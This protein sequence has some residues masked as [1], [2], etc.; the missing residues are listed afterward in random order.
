MT[1]AWKT[2]L[3]T[4]AASSAVIASGPSAH[5]VLLWNASPS[6][7][8][9]LYRVQPDPQPELTQLVVVH[10]PDDLV[11]FLAEGGYLPRGVPLLKRIAALGGQRVCRTGAAVS[12]DGVS[13][14][15]ALAHDHRGRSLPTW[16][17]CVVL[18]DTQVFLFNADRPDSLDGRYFGPLDRKTIVGRAEPLWTDEER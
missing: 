13:L 16:S 4:L 14:G 8:L 1:L 11:W 17:G 2:L 9:G 5:P 7:P 3:T 15:S 6:A 18:T 12:V 10:P